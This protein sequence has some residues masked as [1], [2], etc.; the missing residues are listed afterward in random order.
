MSQHQ[1][2]WRAWERVSC[3]PLLQQLWGRGPRICAS[4]GVP[5]LLLLLVQGP[6]SEKHRCRPFSGPATNTAQLLAF[7]F[8]D[9]PGTRDRLLQCCKACTWTHLASSYKITEKLYS[10][11]NN[12]VHGQLGQILDPKDTKRKT[13]KKKKQLP[14][15]KTQEQKQRVGSKSR[16][17]SMP[18]ALNTT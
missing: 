11:K 7:C 8:R 16:V 17:L 3:S 10:T 14:F 13:K 18:P 4:H 9:T 5:G 1:S 12:C 2:P 6:H 15:L